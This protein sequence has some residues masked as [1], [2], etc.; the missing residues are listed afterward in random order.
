MGESP[1]AAARREAEE[2]TGLEV[3][4]GA[5]VG[6]ALVCGGGRRFLVWNYRAARGGGALRPGGDA[7]EVALVASGGLGALDLSSGLLDWLLG[8]RVLA[9]GVLG[10]RRPVD[11]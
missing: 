7:A 8:H 4:L 3:V 10:G 6:T 2:E 5:L 11:G 9:G 1:A